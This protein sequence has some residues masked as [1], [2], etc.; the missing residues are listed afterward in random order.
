MNCFVLALLFI[1]LEFEKLNKKQER[2][3]QF[4]RAINHWI[5][6]I[7][8]IQIQHGCS[9]DDSI[10]CMRWPMFDVRVYLTVSNLKTLTGSMSASRITAS[11][12]RSDN[13]INTLEMTISWNCG[14]MLCSDYVRTQMNL[15]AEH[16]SC[17]RWNEIESFSPVNTRSY[18][19]H[20][21]TKT[22]SL[23]LAL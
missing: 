16:V 23:S 5:R 11:I 12:L 3:T 18:T 20:T 6:S 2:K 19:D 9:S 10:V 15:T 13:K 8:F 7:S 1:W 21:H 17:V 14:P 4:D 22:H